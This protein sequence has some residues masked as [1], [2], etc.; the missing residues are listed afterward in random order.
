M[1]KHGKPHHKGNHKSHHPHNSPK[2]SPRQGSP[3]KHGHRNSLGLQVQSIKHYKNK[4][5]VNRRD[6]PVVASAPVSK[7]IISR[8][9][10]HRERYL[11]IGRYI[12]LYRDRENNRK[13]EWFSTG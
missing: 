11:I 5:K 6:D 13:I 10:Y 9:G 2:H 7:V 12:N 1:G 3:G 8:V 4:E